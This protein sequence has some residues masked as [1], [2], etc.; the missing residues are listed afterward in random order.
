MI[1]LETEQT[2][3]P[4]TPAPYPDLAIGT[5]S[6][7]LFNDRAHASSVLGLPTVLGLAMW[8][9]IISLV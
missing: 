1:E 5:Y 4:L 7:A 2:E 6:R 9:A 8:Y 3:R